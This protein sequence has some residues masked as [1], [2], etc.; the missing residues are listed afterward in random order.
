MP[1]APPSPRVFCAVKVGSNPLPPKRCCPCGC[2]YLEGSETS[3]YRSKSSNSTPLSVFS[4]RYLIITGV[5]T[6]SPHSAALPLVIARAPA[7]TTALSGTTSGPSLRRAVNLPP[8]RIEQRRR[9]RQDHARAQHRAPSHLRP[10]VDAAVAAHQHVVFNH[11]RTGVHRLQHSANLRRRAHMHPLAHLRARAHQRMGID[12]RPLVH[13]RPHVHIHRRH[14]DHSRRQ[15]GTGP[16][17]RAARN[18]PHPVI[19]LKVPHR[20]RIR[21]T[22][23][24]VPP[25]CVSSETPS[26]KPSRIPASPK[27]WPAS[28][29]RASPLPA[30]HLGQHI[31]KRHKRLQAPRSFSH[32]SPNSK[33]PFNLVSQLP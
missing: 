2:L 8:H 20:K 7:T 33:Q 19:A 26:R 10:F 11:H 16:H 22:N 31:A 15:I 25:A 21:S 17:R 29:R 6:L 32:P 5:Y 24:N 14:A 28:A 3:P 1:G 4:S 13:I 27:R 23:E 12:H 18:H 9:A 30:A